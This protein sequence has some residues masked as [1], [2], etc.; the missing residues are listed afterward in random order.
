MVNDVELATERTMKAVDGYMVP[1]RKNF[2]ERFPVIFL[3]CVTVVMTATFLGIE[4]VILKYELFQSQP[5]L[6]L[7]LGI[8]MLFITGKINK[9]LG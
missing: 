9:K 3:L 1:V 2:L 5:E 6:I 4:Q 8:L 7:A